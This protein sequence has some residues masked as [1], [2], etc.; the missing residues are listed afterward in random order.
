M[1]LSLLL[2]ILMTFNKTFGKV[3][4]ISRV[5][6]CDNKLTTGP[7]TDKSIE[8]LSNFNVKSKLISHIFVGLLPQGRYFQDIEINL[9]TWKHYFRSENR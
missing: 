7:A 2:D 3:C 9:K 1:S 8:T 4:L 5:K 6:K